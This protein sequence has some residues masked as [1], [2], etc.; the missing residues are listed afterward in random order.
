MKIVYVNDA[1][2][3]W[4]GLERILVEKIN[5]L[6]E[7]FGYEVYLLTA[8]QGSH[9]LPYPLHPQTVH[10][11]LDILFYQQYLYRGIRRYLKKRELHRL[12]LHCLR[13][14]IRL[15]QPDVIVCA[16]L[17]YLWDVSRVRGN[18]PLAFESHSSC[19]LRHFIQVGWLT[20]LKYDYYNRAARR[21]DQVVALT[22]GDAAAWRK[23]NPNVSVIPDFVHLNPTDRFCDY[24]AKSVIFVGRFSA[25]KDISTLLQIWR[26][27]H[28][29]HPDWTLQIFG[30]YGEEQDMLLPQIEQMN[31]NVVVHETTPDI[32]ER[33]L[34]NSI[35]LLTSRFEPFGLVLPEAMS[36]GLPVVAFDCPYGP[37][38]IISDGKDGFLIR[39]RDIHSYAEKVCLLMESQELRRSMG[40]AGVVSSRRYDP[41]IIMPLWKEFFE[42]QVTKKSL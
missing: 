8:N 10:R 4:G 22:D 15:I 5:A 28:Q 20:R 16:R 21:A 42:R 24:A 19:L 27:V 12:F 33:Y 35:L 3:I 17:E 38:N 41:S 7:L 40:Q 36:C 29:R 39:N 25:Q 32:F 9:P 6:T 18:I 14:Q 11:D 34:E 2:A 13:E 1:I 23:L 37:V 26:V 31:C 30:G